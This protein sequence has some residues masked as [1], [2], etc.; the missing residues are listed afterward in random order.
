MVHAMVRNGKRSPFV[1]P[2]AQGRYLMKK[3]PSLALLAIL[4]VTSACNIGGGNPSALATPVLPRVGLG[5]L[6]QNASGGFSAAGQVIQYQYTV[7]NT[8]TTALDGPVTV[9]DDKV[10]VT[11]PALNTAGNLNA[12]LDPAESI[13]CTGSYTVKPEDVTAGQVTNTATASVGG[14]LSNP[15]NA[16]VRMAANKVL[17]LAKTA[18]PMTFSQAG[19]TITFT[20]V[21]TNTGAQPVGPAQFTV[22][23]DHITGAISCGAPNTTL[24]TNQNVTC[25]AFYTTTQADVTA[26]RVTNTASAAGGTAASIQPATVTLTLAGAA[27]TGT[28]GV[29]ITASNLTPGTTVQYKVVQGEWLIQIARCFGVDPKALDQAN[30]QIDDPDE[31]DPGEVLTIPNIGSKGRLYGPPCI[32]SHTVQ[33]GDTWSSIAAKYNADV[34]VL[35][36][37]NVG[38]SL[39]A[40][41]VLRIPLNS[42]GATVSTG[43]T[44]VTTP[45]VTTCNQ[46]Q[47]VADVNMPDGTVVTAGANFTKTWRLKNVGTCTWTSGY[48]LIWDHGEPMGAPATMPLTTASVPPGSTVDV[49][50]P[51][52]APAAAGT[53]Q[54]DFRM[55]APD[56][57]V[58]GIGPGGQSTFWVKIAVT[59]TAGATVLPTVTIAPT[60]ATPQ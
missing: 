54:A 59:G 31:L 25:T 44:A 14:V 42:A 4:L 40:G 15:T 39:T 21:I 16:T 49:S 47:L 11:C 22:T 41:T 51:L 48:L 13:I 46:A 56:G 38:A 58:F 1:T 18:S 3:I 7:T 32:G 9:L 37:A 28:D 24:T 34:A 5:I 35:Q 36:A 6:P 33:A 26:G 17:S 19:Q 57:I 20:Y 45:V 52:R 23:D 55:R 60:A 30:P 50:V 8:G 43:A 27:G 53:Y 2:L 12:K 10:S 29:P